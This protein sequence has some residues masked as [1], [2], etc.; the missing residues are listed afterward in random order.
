M[1]LRKIPEPKAVLRTAVVLALL[2]SRDLWAAAS[3]IE[4]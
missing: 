3:G 4:A 2:S 1:F